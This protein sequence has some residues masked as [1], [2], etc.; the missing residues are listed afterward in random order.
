MELLTR[1][2]PRSLIQAHEPPC[3]S[4]Y[5]PTHRHYPDNQQ[6][7]IRFRDLVR[8]TD[9]ARMRSTRTPSGTSG[10]WTDTAWSAV[11]P[12]FLGRLA[13][14]AEAFTAGVARQRATADLSDASRAALEGRVAHLLVEAHRIIPGQI[15]AA[16]GA[17]SAAPIG[18]PEVGDMLDDLAEAVLRT[19]GN[20]V[21]VPKDRMPSSSG[22][23]AI[24]RY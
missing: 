21:V 17:I 8:A 22:L 9:L 12:H 13:E 20:V 7:P 6:D 14:L 23:A 1:D 3:V 11:E 19:G 16:T 4:L 18:H 10:R 2:T 24:L 15:D 5:Q